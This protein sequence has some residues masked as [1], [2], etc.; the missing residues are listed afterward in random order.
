VHKDA[1]AI[2]T[3]A[4]A[5]IWN[6]KNVIQQLLAE[7][8]TSGREQRSQRS[9]LTPEKTDKACKRQPIANDMK[10]PE[11]LHWLSLRKNFVSPGG[12]AENKTHT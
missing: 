4:K 2:I 10:S 11:H 5:T 1:F 6:R 12:E 9:L 8:G 3:S 7:R